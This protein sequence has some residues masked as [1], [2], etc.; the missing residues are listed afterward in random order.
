M[1]LVLFQRKRTNSV[2][3]GGEEDKN[4]KNILKKNLYFPCSLEF[5]IRR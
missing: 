3:Q 5:Y 1:A 2:S 4:P